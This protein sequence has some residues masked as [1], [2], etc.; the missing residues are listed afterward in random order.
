M[1]VADIVVVPV[2]LWSAA[3]GPFDIIIL[4][5]NRKKNSGPIWTEQDE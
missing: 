5:L 3:E 2:Q 4:S 1:V